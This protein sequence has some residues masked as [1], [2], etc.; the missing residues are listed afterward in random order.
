MN[1][2]QIIGIVV[3]GFLGV[4][5]YQDQ[6]R[7]KQ[8]QQNQYYQTML[9]LIQQN[10]LQNSYAN[11][12]FVP[13]APPSSQTDRFT[14]WFNAVVGLYGNVSGLWQP[15]GPF[16]RKEDEITSVLGAGVLTGGGG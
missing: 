3:L 7:R 15:G 5:W 11:F 10:Q 4:T 14:S 1:N 16:Y 8:L 9:Q 2:K 6:Q 13:Q 12:P